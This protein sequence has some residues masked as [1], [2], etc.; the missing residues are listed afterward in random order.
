L[1]NVAQPKKSDSNHKHAAAGDIP[2]DGCLSWHFARH[3]I[4]RFHDR[5]TPVKFV[6]KRIKICEWFALAGLRISTVF[7]E[8]TLLHR[9]SPR[10]DFMIAQ[11]PVKFVVVH[12]RFCEWFALAGLRISTDFARPASQNGGPMSEFCATR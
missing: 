3:T 1:L 12:V 5:A 9:G 4:G 8:P 2:T 6:L 7:V 11:T 10:S